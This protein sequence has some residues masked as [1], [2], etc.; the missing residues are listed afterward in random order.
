MFKN[1]RFHEGG[2][3]WLLF[4]LIEVRPGFSTESREFKHSASLL[5]Q[6]DLVLKICLKIHVMGYLLTV[7]VIFILK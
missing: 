4:G 7:S 6:W 1:A 3:F 2:N 5:L